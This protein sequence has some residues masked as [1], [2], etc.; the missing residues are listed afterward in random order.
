MP[1]K[2]TRKTSN[3]TGRSTKSTPIKRKKRETAEAREREDWD[4]AKEAKPN[5]DQVSGDQLL[6]ATSG[7]EG[8]EAIIEDGEKKAREAPPLDPDEE[9]RANPT[10]FVVVTGG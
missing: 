3:K 9:A 6:S 1:K 5:K 4:A 2:S 7:I 8:Q 10:G